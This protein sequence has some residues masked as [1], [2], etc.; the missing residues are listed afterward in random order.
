MGHIEVL[1][2]CM[3]DADEQS[4]VSTDVDE[5]SFVSTDVDEQ[6]FVRTD[7]DGGIGGLIV[8]CSP[9]IHCCTL[10]LMAAVHLC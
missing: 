3:D 4:F 5:Q 1:I 10:V 8:A 6:S 9:V 7:A 2:L